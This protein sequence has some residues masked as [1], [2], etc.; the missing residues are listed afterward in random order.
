MIRI[1]PQTAVVEEGTGKGGEIGYSTLRG[2]SVGCNR[3]RKARY[4]FNT[5][6]RMDMTIKIARRMELHEAD[7]SGEQSAVAPHPHAMPVNGGRLLSELLIVTASICE[8]VE[9]T[10][11]ETTGA[12]ENGSTLAEEGEGKERGRG[13]G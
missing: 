2:D 9:Q 11:L 4:I 12:Q 8:N 10:R 3:Q 13:R 1:T 5:H 7:E 6:K